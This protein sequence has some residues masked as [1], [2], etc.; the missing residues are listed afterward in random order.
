VEQPHEAFGNSPMERFDPDSA[1][2]G[3]ERH[4]HSEVAIEVEGWF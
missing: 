3:P 2:I 4:W 1:Y